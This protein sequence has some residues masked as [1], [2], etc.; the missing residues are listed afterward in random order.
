M[1]SYAFAR[2]IEKGY[3][4]P[5]ELDVIIDELG[6]SETV[7]HFVISGHCDP[8]IIFV[9]TTRDF[10]D[11]EKADLAQAIAESPIPTSS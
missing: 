10:S 6:L 7:Q 5:R 1:A 4:P 3:L 8:Y 2:A 11:G 9:E